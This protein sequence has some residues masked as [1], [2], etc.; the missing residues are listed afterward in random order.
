MRVCAGAV[1][2]Q[3]ALPEVAPPES[4][5]PRGARYQLERRIREGVPA[6]GQTVEGREDEE[7]RKMETH[8]HTPNSLPMDVPPC[9]RVRLH[10]LL[11]AS[12]TPMSACVSSSP[13]LSSSSPVQP[14]R[15]RPVLGRVRLPAAGG[16]D[17]PR[18]PGGPRRPGPDGLH[19]G[20]APG[21]RS[22]PRDSAERLPARGRPLVGPGQADGPTSVAARGRPHLRSRRD[23]Q[24]LRDESD[25]THHP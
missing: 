11:S 14:R 21:G 9:V 18:D 6:Q 16:R 25:S 20:R 1:R 17:Q 13:F 12:L 19:A 23:G 10:R 15:V 24:V 8:T 3:A 22:I 2:V 7:R 5:Q 4:R